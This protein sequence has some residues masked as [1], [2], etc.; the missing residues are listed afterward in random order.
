MSAN[1]HPTILIIDDEAAVRQSIADHLEDRGYQIVEAQN[2]R[3]GLNLFDSQ[4]IDLV[5][6]D[7]RMPEVDGLE[8]LSRI[9]QESP[10]TPLIVVSGTGVISDAIEA[11]RQGAWDFILKPIS[12]FSVLTHTIDNAIEKARLKRENRQYQSRLEEIVAE[13]TRDLELANEHLIKINPR[14]KRIVDT[15]RLLAFCTKVKSFGIQLLD[16]FGQ[17]MAA[18]GGSLYLVEGDGLHLLHALDPGHAPEFIAFPVPEDSAFHRA[19]TEKKPILITDF[20]KET[21]FAASGWEYYDNSSTLVFPLQEESGEVTAILTL[22]N[23]VPPPFM[24]QDKEIGSILASYSCEALRAVRATE[25]LRQ[26]E[27]QFRLI[28]DTIRVGII[29]VEISTR[30]IV[31]ANPTAVN[32]IGSSAEE[33]IGAR[34]Q[35]TLCVNNDGLCPAL[36]LDQQDESAERTLK[37]S[38]GQL[39]PVLKTIT[40][41]LYQGKECLLES[42]FDL[43]A[44]K[45]SEAEKAALEKML[46]QAQKMEALGTLAGGIAHDFNNIL[47]AI[48]GYTELSFRLTDD[49]SHPIRQKLKAI[50]H[51]GER[52]KSLVAQILAFS[53]M[54]E[55]MLIPIQIAPIIKEALKLLQA[56]LPANIQL[57]TKIKSQR[58]VL[59][60]PTQIHQ[61]IMNLCTN[62]YH[63]MEEKGGQLTVSLMPLSDND[64]AHLPRIDLPRGDYLCLIVEDTG[65][66]IS[67][68]ILDQ[69]FDPYFSTKPKEKGTGLGLAVVHS[70]VKSH[71]GAI[72]VES[73]IDKGT[74]FYVIL[75]TT[76]DILE[77][78]D[79]E[80]KPLPR[81]NERILLVDDEKELVEIVYQM[82]DSLGYDVTG[83]TGSIEAL[84]LF[85]QS[86]DHFDLVI[87]DMNMPA[88]SGDQLA[89]E[90]NRIRPGVPIILCTGFSERLDPKKASMLG[91]QG[92][93][94]KPL[95]MNILAETIRSVLCEP[96]NQQ[97]R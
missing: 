56:S 86:P 85:K 39:L 9:A 49:A 50:L 28:L 71:G 20:T 12:D 84:R 4:R 92:F 80:L 94:M 65:T 70:I 76:E 42:F 97:S 21:S 81:G 88:M 34:C 51:A 23:K 44:Q 16:E 59:A 43:T 2:G 68:S 18:T 17:H 78:I 46:R 66:G 47:A 6:V 60:D 45:Q 82:L 14:L 89:Q 75:P 69:I 72:F 26:S 91:I 48:I 7:L 5:L 83:V 62:A 25:N 11:L 33:L 67:P 38:S 79:S 87:T 22:H 57:T 52:A 74:A 31:Y 77:A 8:V 1:N 53:R 19:I 36:D 10:E 73:R 13:R 63:A 41:I 32:T 95:A 96:Q 35:D 93:L 90:M 58:Q 24:E 40:R 3:I 15:T 64:L 55:Q 27:Q 54:K 29:I 61:I 37:N 30:Q